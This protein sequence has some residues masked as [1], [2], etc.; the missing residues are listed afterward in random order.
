[1]ARIQSAFRTISL[2]L[3]LF[4]AKWFLIICLVF[5]LISIIWGGSMLRGGRH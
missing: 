4:L 2:G 1:M 5:I 3:G